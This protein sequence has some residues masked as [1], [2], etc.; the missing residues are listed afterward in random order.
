MLTTSSQEERQADR[1]GLHR[2]LEHHYGFD[3]DRFANPATGQ[4]QTAFA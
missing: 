3:A 4:G 2:R 1:M